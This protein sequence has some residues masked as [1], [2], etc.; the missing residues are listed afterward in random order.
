MS[1]FNPYRKW[2]PLLEQYVYDIERKMKDDMLEEEWRTNR[3]KDIRCY[4]DWTGLPLTNKEL[5]E[6]ED[7]RNDATP[8][9]IIP[10]E[11]GIVPKRAIMNNRKYKPR[12]SL[13]KEL[14]AAVY[15]L[16]DSRCSRCNSDHANQIHHK[17]NNPSNNNIKNL[18]LLCYDCHLITEGKE[19]FRV[20]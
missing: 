16:Y 3:G 4:D 11:N 18:Q 20:E 14:R 12:K 8:K 15:Q 13:S 2:D 19:K 6:L 10:D 5:Q 9:I 17:D 1:W 7:E